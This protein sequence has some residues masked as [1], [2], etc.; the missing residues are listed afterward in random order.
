MSRM[1]VNVTSISRYFC[2]V[3]KFIRVL[4]SSLDAIG[5]SASNQRRILPGQ[6]KELDSTDQMGRRPLD[7]Q[8][9][10]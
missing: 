7:L 1:N 4:T 2:P 5:D 9:S 6:H 10:Q 3:N 8:K